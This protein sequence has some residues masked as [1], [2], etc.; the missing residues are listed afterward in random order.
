MKA[1]LISGVYFPPQVGG[2]SRFMERVAAEL[3][4]DHVCCLTGADEPRVA[5]NLG[6]PTIYRY[7]SLTGDSRPRKAVGW[8]SAL[9]KIIIRERPRVI[10]LGS[11]EDS[12]FGLWL[13]RWFRLPFI[14]FAYGNEI[15]ETIQRQYSRQLAA[16][17]LA[18]RVLATSRYTADLALRAGAD[19]Q[20]T[21]VV[22][23]G[24]DTT[25]F[26]PVIA[27]GDLRLRLLG[28]RSADRVILTVGNLVSRKGQ[29][30]VIRALPALLRHVPEVVYLIA[31]SGPY[32]G[33]LEKLA[34]DLG[35]RDRVV[36]AG[37]LPDE[38]LP[39]LYALCDVFVMV[40]RERIEEN[41]VEGFGMALLEANACGKPVIG[42]RSGGVPDALADNVTGLLVDPSSADEISEALARVLTDHEL[43]AR[44]GEQGRLRVLHEFQW[45]QVG[46]RLLDILRVVRLEGSR[47]RS[48][49]MQTLSL[50]NDSDV[51]SESRLF[52]SEPLASQEGGQR[53][54][55][56]PETLN[57]SDPER[58][59]CPPS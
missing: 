58:G 39:D 10:I 24:C 52:K 19:P 48:L 15:L 2:I 50:R 16:L 21:T 45:E 37:H 5:D 57:L 55:A 30:M 14:V 28:T 36:F 13:H 20:R 18:N 22:W 44:F 34:S 6:G 53:P 29:D 26:R 31:G 35:V 27:K 49:L 1:L 54:R 43:A 38:D 41:D 7:P 59:R 56:D 12:Y 23:P 9:T 47:S 33:E 42:G 46:T 17:S 32:Q 3:G 25:V 40:S 11:V 51:Q 4:Q 8:A